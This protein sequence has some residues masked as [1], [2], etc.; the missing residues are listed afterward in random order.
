MHIL[1]RAHSS[2]A[3]HQAHEDG[4]RCLSAS[5]HCMILFYERY[6]RWTVKMD[7]LWNENKQITEETGSSQ[8]RK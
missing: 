4:V 6:E 8:T 5:D 3:F 7:S 1:S 2:T